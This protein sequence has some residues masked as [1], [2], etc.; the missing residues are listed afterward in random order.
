MSG[1]HSR[2]HIGYE[3][4]VKRIHDGAIGDIVSIEENF[5]RAP[6]VIIDRCLT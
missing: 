5:L 4:T 1:L 6:Y 2:Y 3:E